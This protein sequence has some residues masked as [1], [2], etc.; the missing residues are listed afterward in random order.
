MNL[1]YKILSFFRTLFGYYDGGGRQIFKSESDLDL[2]RCT[3]HD[4][5]E[6]NELNRKKWR[7]K[8]H[9]GKGLSKEALQWYDDD[10]ILID[11]GI[12]RLKITR[13]H[14]G[15]DKRIFRSGMITTGPYDK[16]D[17]PR[18]FEQLYGYF[19]IR[20]KVP[21]GNG[22]WSAF[23]LYADLPEIDIMEIGGSKTNCLRSAYHYGKSYK[24][25]DHKVKGIK[26]HIPDA[27]KG[28][29]TYG[30][31]WEPNKLTY[32][33]DGYPIGII[34]GNF[35]CKYPRYIIINL[36]IAYPGVF[37][38]TLN[39]N[40]QFPSYLNIDYVKVFKRK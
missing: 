15:V 34:K 16:W 4:N 17:G 27:S 28:Y 22:F 30:V 6:I 26:V 21:K 8:H 12:C 23:W 25:K 10:H 1:W 19:E 24:P 31:D 40:T 36:G 18:L 20:C 29:H 35:I 14:E 3:F 9:W 37:G 32:Y 33:F 5:F 39:E 38:E 11:R 13:E 7:K 2:W